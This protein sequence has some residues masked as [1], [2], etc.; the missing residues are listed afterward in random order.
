MPDG[1]YAAVTG[2]DKKVAN[3]IKKKNKAE[4]K[5]SLLFHHNVKEDIDRISNYFGAIADL[6]E[7]TPD[8]VHAK[9]NSYTGLRGGSD[10]LKAKSACDLWTAAFFA[11]LDGENEAAVPTTR[12][13]WDAIAG[14]PPQA[15]V[16]GLTASLVTSVIE[17]V[18]FF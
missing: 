11:P 5:G 13:V 12:D 16:A 7:T 4:A 1:A 15:P 17:S 10:W 9:E 2:D 6:A 8:E 18:V 14:R 3:A